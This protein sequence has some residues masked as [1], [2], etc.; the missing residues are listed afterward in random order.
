MG[1]TDL[2]MSLQEAGR[3]V[4]VP[5][6]G[7]EDS[8]APAAGT[9]GNLGRHWRRRRPDSQAD[10]LQALCWPWPQRQDGCR[11]ESTAGW[12]ERERRIEAGAQGPWPSKGATMTITP[13]TSPRRPAPPGMVSASAATHWERAWS[14]PCAEA[15][16]RLRGPGEARAARNLHWR[17]QKRGGRWTN[18]LLF[19][20]PGLG[21]TTLS[22][23]VAAGTVRVDR[24]GAPW[25]TVSNDPCH[26]TAMAAHGATTRA[27]MMTNPLRGRAQSSSGAGWD[28]PAAHRH[29]QRLHD[30]TPKMPCS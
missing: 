5:G 11:P 13:T 15:A 10:I 26:V 4:K 21:K 18:V 7:K 29:A 24:H 8:R 12:R 20:P 22:R 25:R 9:Q 19:G 3:L 1:V 16:G 2:A 17:G 14:A 27:G 30:A 6:I 28:T 23:I